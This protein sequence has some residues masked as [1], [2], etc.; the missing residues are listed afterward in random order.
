MKKIDITKQ[1]IMDY[2]LKRYKEKGKDFFFKS[3]TIPLDKS[4]CAIGRA[5]SELSKDGKIIQWSDNK[6][7]REKLW[8]T[9][10]KESL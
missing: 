1:E 8:R 4:V 2:L 7:K 5:I 3:Q 10:F 6:G 9:D